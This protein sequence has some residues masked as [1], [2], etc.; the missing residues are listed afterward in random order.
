MFLSYLLYKLLLVIKYTP[1][2]SV[3]CNKKTRVLLFADK[4][5]WQILNNLALA[6]ITYALNVFWQFAD[7]ISNNRN[8]YVCSRIILMENVHTGS[9][10]I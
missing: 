9:A 6:C 7:G 2:E 5:R 4:K 10:Y 8:M 3:D 1:V